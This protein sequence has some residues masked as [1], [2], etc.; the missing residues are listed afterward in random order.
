MKTKLNFLI[1][2][3]LLAFGCNNSGSQNNVKTVSIDEL[4]SQNKD[5]FLFLSF[6]SGMSKQEFD[7]I[8]QFENEKGNL[9]DGKFLLMLSSS[10]SIPF[11]VSYNENSI[12]LNY[13]DAQWATYRGNSF[14]ALNEIESGHSYSYIEDFIEDFFNEKYERISPPR[15]QQ[16]KLNYLHFK[17]LD[18][19]DIDEYVETLERS[20]GTKHEV[21]AEWKSKPDDT[22]TKFI[23]LYSRYSFL[24]KNYDLY[25]SLSGATIEFY[26]DR[27]NK[28]IKIGECEISIT[29]EF[30]DEHLQREKE[31]DTKEIE[32][33]KKREQER[34][35]IENQII[36]NNNN[37]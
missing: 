33:K 8:K 16:K 26:H 27:E 7:Q 36:K 28:K 4:I 17:S 19:M 34:K 24:D 2:L 6:W 18:E 21:T 9:K 14:D 37:L 11:D 12:I 15:Q 29:Y 23:T 3:L 32:S 5:R 30:Y 10:S 31:E 25:N 35:E 13:S 20:H 22:R 1:I